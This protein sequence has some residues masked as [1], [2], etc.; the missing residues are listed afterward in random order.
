MEHKGNDAMTLTELETS[1]YEHLNQFLAKRNFCLMP[2]LYQ[3]RKPTET[4]FQN[5]ILTTTRYESELW[6]EVNIGVRID[7]V[8]NL[9]QQFL[10]V[11]P[12]Y[13]KHANTL[14]ISIG[15]LSDTKYLRYKIANQEDVFLTVQAIKDFMKG[16]GFDFLE[17]NSYIRHLDCLFNEK[18]H[19]PLK[20]VYN[21]IH[22]CF[23]GAILA[24]Y[25]NNP[26]FFKLLDQYQLQLEK[27][28]P[29]TLI[30]ENY[31]KLANYLV[32]LSIN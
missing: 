3:F 2:E 26:H 14:I 25:N 28:R 30:M 31:I 23:K 11:T 4:G 6:V 7:T 1:L 20:Y 12:E 16:R 19:Q 13:R 10:D 24:K 8:E 18:P 5:L 9:A 29:A 22:R 15:K 27:L 17:H 21:Q 32:Y